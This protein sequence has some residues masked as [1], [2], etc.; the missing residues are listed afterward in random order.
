MIARPERRALFSEMRPPYQMDSVDKEFPPFA[1]ESIKKTTL[2]A[3][4][5]YPIA[6][7][8]KISTVAKRDRVACGL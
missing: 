3:V 7:D 2:A 8:L 6:S 5:V 4:F 1:F